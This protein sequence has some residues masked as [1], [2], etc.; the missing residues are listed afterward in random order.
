[1]LS[2]DVCKTELLEGTEA[3]SQMRCIPCGEGRSI[4]RDAE[5]NIRRF[6]KVLDLKNTRLDRLM[7]TATFAD[8]AITA[9]VWD[10]DPRFRSRHLNVGTSTGVVRV[11]KER[12]AIEV[13]YPLAYDEDDVVLKRA[14]QVILAALEGGAL[15]EQLAIS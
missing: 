2:C 9:A 15:T 10:L 14:T 4:S 12:G 11:I 6:K 5:Q 13:V 3:A 7:D 1:M 8:Y